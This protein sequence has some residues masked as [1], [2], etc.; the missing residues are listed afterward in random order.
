MCHV[1]TFA[2]SGRIRKRAKACSQIRDRYTMF[3]KQVS[4]PRLL[5]IGL[6]FHDSLI[7][8][9]EDVEDCFAKFTSLVRST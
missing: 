2:L 4:S 5:G 6:P 7:S 1:F 9:A 8:S 3:I